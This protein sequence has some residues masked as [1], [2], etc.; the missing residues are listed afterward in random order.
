MR[1]LVL[2]ALALVLALGATA[3]NKTIS[4]KRV[5]IDSTLIWQGDTIDFNSYIGSGV[6]LEHL[7]FDSAAAIPAHR[8]GLLFYDSLNKSL[9]YYNDQREVSNQLGRELWTRCYNGS[10]ADLPNGTVVYL[11]TSYQGR[12]TIRP[13]QAN[14]D[15]TVCRILGLTTQGIGSGEFGEVCTYGE[16]RGLNTSALTMRGEVYVSPTTAGAYTSTRPVYPDYEVVVGSVLVV[17]ATEGVIFVTRS[18]ATTFLGLSDTPASYAGQGGKVVKVAGGETALE[19]AAESDP[20]YVA[21]VASQISAADTVA[22]RTAYNWGNHAAAGYI[23]TESDPVYSASVAAQ[24]RAEDTLAYRT[25]YE[26][27]ITG[28]S[29]DT[30]TGVLTLNQEAGGAITQD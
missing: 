20:V 1:K 11:D 13:A 26:R 14:T 8:E 6:A 27:H 25:A 16:V 21:S 7:R 19:F 24:I 23:T 4:A 9:S 28:S 5:L 30:G 17:D 22:Y 18:G 10:G 15:T 2:I 12:P 29:F 3:Q